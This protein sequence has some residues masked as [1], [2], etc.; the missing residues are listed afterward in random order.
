MHRWSAVVLL[1]ALAAVTTAAVTVMRSS[2]LSAVE[3]QLV[4]RWYGYVEKPDGA[5]YAWLS[6]RKPNRT[7]TIQFREFCDRGEAA[8]VEIGIWRVA[9]N[10]M[11]AHTWRPGSEPT[12]LDQLVSLVEARRPVK[13]GWVEEY[14]IV[15]L[16]DREYVCL[17]EGKYTYR[18]R[19]VADDFQLPERPPAELSA[20]SAAAPSLPRP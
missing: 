3:Q 7:C 6:E 17:H 18:S 8:P 12:L 10:R 1:L 14:E 16:T 9:G 13:H 15:S 20:V 19:K 5:R 11:I 4:G 2:E